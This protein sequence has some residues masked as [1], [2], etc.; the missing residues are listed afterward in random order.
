MLLSAAAVLCPT[1]LRA[2]IPVRSLSQYSQRVYRTEEGLPQNEVRSIAQTP[3]GYLWFGTRDGLARFDGVR[4]TVFRAETTPGLGHN[5]F[6]ALLVDHA[7]KLW[8]AT[9]DGLSCYEHGAF[10]RYTERDGLPTNAIHSLLEDRAGTVWAGTWNGL[11]AFDGA[12][13]RTYNSKNGLPDDSIS[14]LAEDGQGG[15]WIGTFGGGLA[16]MAG[17]RFRVFTGKDGLPSGV[18][19]AV[20]R[21]SSGKLWV[22]TQ[23]GT[24]VLAPSGRFENVRGLPGKCNFLLE[25]GGGAIWAATDKAL[26]RYGKTPGSGFEEQDFPGG[27]AETMFEDRDGSLWVGTSAAGVVRYRA[28]PFVT[29]TAREGLANNGVQT[30]FE[31]SKANLWIG[32]TD[33]LSR[34][35][36]GQLQTVA[37]TRD[38][39]DG[40]VRSIAEDDRG[41]IW[42]GTSKG[43]ALFDGSRWKQLGAHDQIPVEV[44]TLYPDRA[45]R[46]W[47]GSPEGVTVWDHGR[48]SRI[49][50]RD[51]LPGNYVMSILEDSRGR[52]WVGTVTGLACL[53]HGKIAS[54]AKA[55]GLLSN[56]IQSL[57]EDADGTLWICT[58]SGLHRF[59]DGHFRA[60][61][62]KDGMYAD[63]TLRLLEDEQR[64]F[65]I[66]SYRGV[67]RVD[68]DQLNAVAGG[69]RTRIESVA[70]GTE[71]GM[72]S[73]VCAGLGMQP[74][75]WRSRNG[76]LWFPTYEGVVSVT[77][78][79]LPAPAPPP[80]PLLEAVLQDG[81]AAGGPNV[82][83]EIRRLEFAFSAPTSIAPEAVEF[84]YRMLGY[85]DQW[86]DAGA[87][88]LIAFTN[89]PQ[90]SHRFE[91]SARRRGGPWSTANAVS[92]VTV[93]PHFYET[94]S[95]YEVCG[96]LTL[97][98]LWLA[99]SFRVRQTERRLEAVMAERSRVAQELHDTLLQSFSGTAMQVQA[100][101]RRLQQGA[102]DTGARQISTALLH[103]GKSMAEARQAIWDLKSPELQELQLHRA[104][105]AASER[106]CAGGPRLRYVV[107][108]KPKP[109]GP[110]LEKHIYRIGVEAVTNAVRHSGCEEVAVE[111]E[112]RQQS[113]CLRVRDNGR[114]FPVTAAEPAPGGNHWGLTGIRERAKQCSARFTIHSAPGAGTDLRFEAPFRTLVP[115][116]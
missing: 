29:Y 34:W 113:I 59:R 94:R 54:Y 39:G 6:G 62:V 76:A 63:S 48:V 93:L 83:P 35:S 44:H 53:D 70:Y 101:L 15:L 106:V 81:V 18:I 25:G 60:F 38:L 91:V 116:A 86:R 28:G 4:F 55:N 74:A 17:G 104:L 58:P 69:A 5:M 110:C 71:D 51:G 14:G 112:Y 105:E 98:L 100:G 79:R 107:S 92:S 41:R 61:T 24:A 10:R 3:D 103:M 12:H 80:S 87:K 23:D 96:L 33:G 22:G 1:Q 84:R 31:D 13:F 40:S 26:A 109:L 111:L 78:G 16:H 57:Y 20:L 30:V 7:G 65:W 102:A 9:A 82:P 73:S 36:H 67:F 49:S 68:K 85:E 52:V 2:Q 97:L 95:F 8:I 72:K 64:H 11:A 46:V 77:P 45:G 47:I 88:R 108:G 43:V 115:N 21:D 27:I 37:R 42:A 32:T 66:S 114:G 75:G 99:H 89:L 19:D 56:Y 50:T 90:G